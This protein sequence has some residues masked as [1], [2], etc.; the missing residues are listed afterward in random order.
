MRLR[1]L[2]RPAWCFWVW[3]FVWRIWFEVTGLADL[4]SP[5]SG[6]L[7]GPEV[8]LVSSGGVGKRRI[9][10]VDHSFESHSEAFYQSIFVSLPNTFFHGSLSFCIYEEASLYC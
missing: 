5:R 8:F 6:S 7:N 4:I 9:S 3:D 10:V 2:S 1:V